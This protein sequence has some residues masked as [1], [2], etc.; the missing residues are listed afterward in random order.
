MVQTHLVLSSGAGDV[1]LFVTAPIFLPI[2]TSFASAASFSLLAFNSAASCSPLES[3]SAFAFD[4]RVTDGFLPW[5]SA[6]SSF[7]ALPLISPFCCFLTGVARGFLAG[8]S[9]SPSSSATSA[10]G[11]VA[12]ASAV[13][14]ASFSALLLRPR[15]FLGIVVGVAGGLVGAGVSLEDG[16]GVFG[17]GALLRSLG[18]GP[19][20][21]VE[22]AGVE[23]PHPLRLTGGPGSSP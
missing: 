15:F 9:F 10:G 3:L 17:E 1:W 16:L 23:A 5:D 19:G 18:R 14:S 12:V 4:L 13:A 11:L 8:F 2:N 22:S 7:L 21:S 20:F 6:T